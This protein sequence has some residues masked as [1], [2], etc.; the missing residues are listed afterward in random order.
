MNGADVHAWRLAAAR[1]HENL[2]D[3][4]TLVADARRDVDRAV[5]ALR[6]AIRERDRS[7][8]HLRAL[9]EQADAEGMPA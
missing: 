7:E 6:E 3:Y 1:A 5:R 9:L 8:A 4:D 2:I